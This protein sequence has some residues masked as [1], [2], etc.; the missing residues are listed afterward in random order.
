MKYSNSQENTETLQYYVV[1]NHENQY[2]IWPTY[3]A[4]PNGWFIEG[5]AGS[6]EVCLNYIEKTWVDMRPLSLIK[7]MESS[8]I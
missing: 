6:K 1:K 8:D 2:S 5:D 3:K 4:I 7:E